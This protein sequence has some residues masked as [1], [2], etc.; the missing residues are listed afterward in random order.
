M[1]NSTR[2]V[3]GI[4]LVFIVVVSSCGTKSEEEA[5]IDAKKMAEDIFV[6]NEPIETNYELNNMAFYLPG[7]V[8]V[9]DEVD[10]NIILS[11]SDRTYIVF[12]NKIENPLSKLNYSTAQSPNA[13]LLESFS[14]DKKFGYIRIL[15]DEERE[16][17]LQVGVGGVKVTTFTTKMK[18]DDDARELMKVARSIAVQQNESQ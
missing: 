14:N 12:Y 8:E 15:P 7:S 9:T 13:L 5:L 4:M 3:I 11:D 17:E 2:L 6:N 16:Y 18:M 10:S 1:K